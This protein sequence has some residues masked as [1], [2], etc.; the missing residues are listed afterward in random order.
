MVARYNMGGALSSFADID[1]LDPLTTPYQ[2][3]RL[4]ISPPQHSPTY[5]LEEELARRAAPVLYRNLAD[6]GDGSTRAVTN[7]MVD[8]LLRARNASSINQTRGTDKLLAPEQLAE[9]TREPS[10]TERLTMDYLPRGALFAAD[11]MRPQE[12]H[13]AMVRAEENWKGGNYGTAAAYLG[14]APINAAVDVAGTAILPAVLEKGLAAGAARALSRASS[15]ADEVLGGS[16]AAKGG[17]LVAGGAAMMPDEA[18]AGANPRWF[19]PLQ[20]AIENA[21]QAKATL[22]QWIGYL[23]NRPGIKAEEIEYS[24]GGKAKDG[25]ILDLDIGSAP[26]TKEELLRAID[27]IP[28]DELYLGNP[29]TREERGRLRE[30]E[31]QENPF[32]ETYREFTPDE[33]DEYYSLIGKSNKGRAGAPKYKDQPA[34]RL[35]GESSDYR[36]IVVTSPRAESDPSISPAHFGPTHYNARPSGEGPS[37]KDTKASQQIG[38]LR[39]DVRELDDGSR[40]FHVDEFQSD[41]AQRALKKGWKKEMTGAETDAARKELKRLKTKLEEKSVDPNNPQEIRLHA[42]G[43]YGD[44]DLMQMAMRVE[45]LRGLIEMGNSGTGIPDRPWKKDWPKLLFRRALWE[46]A[47]EDVD[48]LTWTTADTQSRRWGGARIGRDRLYEEQIPKIAA[49]EAKRLGLMPDAVGQT[50]TTGKDPDLV[51]LQNDLYQE[52]LKTRK[53]L[54]SHAKARGLSLDEYLN[55]HEYNVMDEVVDITSD[56]MAKYGRSADPDDALAETVSNLV[57]QLL[58]KPQSEHFESQWNKAFP[59]LKQLS[60]GTKLHSL[61]LTPEVRKRIIEE[62]LPKFVGAGVAPGLVE[63]FFADEPGDL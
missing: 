7:E 12:F 28:V 61:K 18:E 46:A 58:L 47:Q 38:W 23:R 43:A 1:N 39:G 41:P 31:D 13:N 14:L 25:G 22:D 15:R 52:A 5:D 45:E 42:S 2:K 24:L 60:G 26:L 4:G 19:S 8:Q 16:R 48:A 55:E 62:G 6:E 20:R 40:A 37:G 53:V 3:L 9:R 36:E 10:F 32:T 49:E 56:I 51:N 35:P 59:I 34:T 54:A 63:R 50:T 33:L 17:A 11:L 44:E 29:L 27:P 57:E 21:P 30:L